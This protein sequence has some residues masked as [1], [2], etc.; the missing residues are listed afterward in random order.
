MIGAL[1][2]STA[3]RDTPIRTIDLFQKTWKVPILS[4]LMPISQR[5]S[6][7]FTNNNFGL[8]IKIHTNN[9][10]EEN[11]SLQKAIPTGDKPLF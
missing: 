8:M 5:I 2:W 11:R 4:T 1:Y 7:R 9:T 10:R 6:F 3:A